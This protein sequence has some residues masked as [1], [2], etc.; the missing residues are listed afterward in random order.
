MTA[1]LK[2]RDGHKYQGLFGYFNS[3]IIGYILLHAMMF[4]G[5]LV[6]IIIHA[7]YDVLIG[8]VQFSKRLFYSNKDIDLIDS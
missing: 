6:A 8:L 1:N 2:F 7:V 4:H 3:W 5:L